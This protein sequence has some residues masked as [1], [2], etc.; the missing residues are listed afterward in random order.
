MIP[1]SLLLFAAPF[2]L[3]ALERKTLR[4][5]TEFLGFSSRKP[6][7]QLG[8]GLFLFVFC[9]ALLIVEGTLL[10][11]AGLLDTEKIVDF[12]LQQP[13]WAL[14]LAVT[15]VPLAEETFFRGY[16]QKKIGV[17]LSSAAFAGLHYGYG[18]IAEII[19]AFSV[20]I[21]FGQWVRKNNALLPVIVAHAAYNAVS[22]AV[23]L[24]VSGA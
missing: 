22:I 18:S 24:S 19:A 12:I 16:L 23:A 6:F 1:L 8:Q 10:N 20:S 7:L 3:L 17:V 21:V 9:L 15:V 5:S 4:Q 2:A 13:G 14:A 11:A